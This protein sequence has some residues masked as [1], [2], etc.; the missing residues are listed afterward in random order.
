MQEPEEEFSSEESEEE[1]FEDDYSSDFEDMIDYY[2]SILFNTFEKV[3]HHK[4]R[5]PTVQDETPELNIGCIFE[6]FE[7]LF[8]QH[9][10]YHG[11]KER[12][13]SWKMERE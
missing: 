10:S 7:K 6:D 8:G 12:F 1:V 11:K 13:L 3:P 4:V 5:I 2:E 9:V